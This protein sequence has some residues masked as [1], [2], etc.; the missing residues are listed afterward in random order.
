M[1]RFLADHRGKMFCAQC[2]AAALGA[3]RRID[4]ALIAAEGRGAQR[5]YGSKFAQSLLR[6]E[7]NRDKVAWTVLGDRVREMV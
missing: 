3:S 2:L 5:L 7:P 6:G 4:R 1:W